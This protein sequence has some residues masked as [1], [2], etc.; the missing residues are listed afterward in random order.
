MKEYFEL[1]F[2]FLKIGSILFGGGYAMLPMLTRELVE[3]RKWVTEEEILDYFAIS[4]CTPGVIAVNT[5]TFIGNK[6]KGIPGG[7]VAT[8]GVISVPLLLI[9][10]IAAVLKNFW[11]NEIIRHA[12]A[13]I[14]TAVAALIFSS[15]VKLFRSNVKNWIGIVLCL[16]AFCAVAYLNV[17]TIYVVLA[18]ALISFLIGR[19]QKE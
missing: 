2:T 8:L 15:V 10:L 9:L 17:S 12:F 13:G 4:Q 7:I 5:A 19:F 16:A 1:Y 11:Q 3:K 6:R 14:R 18:T